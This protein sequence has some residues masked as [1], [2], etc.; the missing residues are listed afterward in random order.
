MHLGGAAQNIQTALSLQTLNDALPAAV[1]GGVDL[2]LAVL[3]AAAGA[4][5]QT[6]GA[7][8]D[9]AD[10]ASQVQEAL[11][12]LAAVVFQRGHALEAGQL[13][14]VAAGVNRLVLQHLGDGL[15]ADTAGEHQHGIRLG[16]LRHGGAQPQRQL[17]GVA[18]VVGGE[19]AHD[20]AFRF[21]LLL[22]S[23]GFLLREADFLAAVAVDDEDLAGSQGADDL[24]GFQF[25]H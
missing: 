16:D 15:H 3:G 17:V 25:C 21:Q 13:D 8:G 20:L 1:H 11:A 12:A 14:G 22:Q 24:F 2:T 10:A 19:N 9:G 4:V 7:G 23:L 5:H 6:L 18:D